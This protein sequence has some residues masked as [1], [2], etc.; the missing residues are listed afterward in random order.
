[1]R[2]RRFKVVLFLAAGVWSSLCLA[3]TSASPATAQ[4]QTNSINQAVLLNSSDGYVTTGN[5]IFYTTMLGSS[6][7]EI[8]PKTA[9]GNLLTSEFSSRGAGTA[10]YTTSDACGAPASIQVFE[11]TTQGSSWSAL[12][13]VSGSPALK[14]FGGHT[15][16]ASIDSQHRWLSVREASS[17]AFSFAD[18]FSTVD[19]GKTWQLLPSPP[20]F[21][22]L[23]FISPSIGFLLGG[24]NDQ[25]LYRTTNG[26]QSWNRV[27]FAEEKVLTREIEVHISLPQ[28]GDSAKGS[29]VVSVVSGAI[30]TT[31]VYRTENGGA[32]WVKT[33]ATS[34]AVAQALSVGTDS[35]NPVVVE[36]QAGSGISTSH[37]N[38]AARVFALPKAD[39]D[40][41][42]TRASFSGNQ[43]GWVVVRSGNAD[44]L[45]LTKDGGT[46]YEDVTP[47]GAR[48]QAATAS[49]A[50]S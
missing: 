25:E 6:W 44:S 1:M 34:G 4:T 48:T 28:F 18:L 15:H 10:Y 49:N 43:V 12:S 16:S 20:V 46:S 17:S 7:T 5:R 21:G 31:T 13:S 3:Q 47:Q 27:P 33:N 23:R 40:A 41:D 14:D 50:G 11:T 9:K 24:F 42:V 39:K 29:V 19:G 8:T 26:G 22:Q 2:T 32:D 45:M 37:V 38:G 30:T 35:S 36:F